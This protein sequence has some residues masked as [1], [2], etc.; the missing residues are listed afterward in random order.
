MH[1]SKHPLAAREV[2]WLEKEVRARQYYEKH[3]EE[4]RKKLEEQRLKEERRRAAVEEKRKQRLEE[5]KSCTSVAF[6]PLMTP[7][8]ELR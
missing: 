8:L 6:S 3:L 4:R 7:I 1:I 5:D 2:A